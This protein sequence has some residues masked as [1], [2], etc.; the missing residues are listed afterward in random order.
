MDGTASAPS[1]M[2]PN[3]SSGI[4]VNNTFDLT[5]SIRFL[6][7]ALA[8]GC[9]YIMVQ[10]VDGKLAFYRSSQDGYVVSKNFGLREEVYV[11]LKHFQDSLVEMPGQVQVSVDERGMLTLVADLAGAG[12]P[13]TMY[14]HTKNIGGTG[15][16]RHEIGPQKTEL[17]PLLFRHFDIKSVKDISRVAVKNGKV[18]IV[19]S[20]GTVYWTPDAPLD[21]IVA[22]SAHFLK[23]IAGNEKVSGLT[24]TEK[25][26]WRSTIGD[27]EVY[28][29]GSLDT[30]NYFGVLDVPAKEVCKLT[31][32]QVMAACR[33]ASNRLPTTDPVT[34][35]PSFGVL[36]I[37]PSSQTQV[38]C[39]LD[40]GVVFPKFRIQAGQAELLYNVLKQSNED[41][42][43][44]S[45]IESAVLPTY[46][47]TRGLFDVNVKLSY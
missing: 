28:I 35:D 40:A 1:I 31:A 32:E 19:S 43:T 7:D 13:T 45:S 42:I 30:R 3:L 4:V 16:T 15:L 39:A 12:L 33:I 27:F 44:I 17:S 47:F 9:A 46:R 5:K 36:F 41:M 38:K 8:Q 14:V 6:N 21:T 25:E 29:K 26:Y 34:F 37:D 24:V 22:P 18:M 11:A 10:F 23:L 20:Q 2:Q